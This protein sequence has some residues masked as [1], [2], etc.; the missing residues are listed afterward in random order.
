MDI[1]RTF[2]A[3][4]G[5]RKDQPSTEDTV[6]NHR[7]M[8]EPTQLHLSPGMPAHTTMWVSWV[9][10]ANCS[11]IVAA[12][13][14]RDPGDAFT[15][16]GPPPTRYHVAGGDGDHQKLGYLYALP[17]ESSYLHHVQ[18]TGLIPGTRYYYRVISGPTLCAAEKRVS[19]K[20]DNDDD[21]GAA[22]ASA[23]PPPTASPSTSPLASPTAPPS[24]SSTATASTMD[25]AAPERRPSDSEVADLLSLLSSTEANNQ[26]NNQANNKP[27]SPRRLSG[28][29]GYGGRSLSGES[30]AVRSPLY[31]FLTLPAPGT[32][33]VRPAATVGSSSGGGNGGSSGGSSG[34]SGG[35]SGGSGS[36][37]KSLRSPDYARAAA[38]AVTVAA[39]GT[40]G[41]PAPMRLAVVGDVGGTEASKATMAAA[42]AAGELD[43]S[44]FGSGFSSGPGCAG[45]SSCSRGPVALLLAGD[46]AYAGGN[47][48]R[49]DAWGEAMAP[50]L[51]E[52][53]L[54]AVAGNHEVEVDPATGEGFSHWRRRFRMPEARPEETAS[55]EVR[56]A[57][58]LLLALRR[59]VMGAAAANRAHYS[60]TRM[61]T[62]GLENSRRKRD[63]SL[64]F[65]FFCSDNV[66]S[67]SGRRR[68]RLR[69]A[70]RLR[71]LVLLLQRWA[72]AHRLPEHVSETSARSW[73]RSVPSVYCCM[74]PD[75]FPALHGFA[76]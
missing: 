29:R 73:C 13:T 67:D 42:T 10:K 14:L 41:A 2:N 1:P 6:D 16:V 60:F 18:L 35:S 59:G 52:L 5:L 31:S 62:S 12:S 70:V 21:G 27:F 69:S 64:S 71:R 68:V 61:W 66:V 26:A 72:C 19:Q 3:V 46:L 40:P 47:G 53:P 38:A 22:E 54:V 74:T 30:G 11:S 34:G 39:S 23:P 32:G 44:A 9:T 58:P 25:A 37:A 50:V 43:T 65:F 55:G 48:S 56:E 4:F 75:A 63:I 8:C 57:C 36:S 49:W 28:E 17:Y 7:V 45:G 20:D 24:G 15:Q 33:F 51:S 76:S